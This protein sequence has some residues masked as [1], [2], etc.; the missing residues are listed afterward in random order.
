LHNGEVVR[1]DDDAEAAVNALAANGK[2]IL[3]HDAR[4][5]YPDGGVSEVPISA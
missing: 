2:S 3:G 5:L 4:S 1:P